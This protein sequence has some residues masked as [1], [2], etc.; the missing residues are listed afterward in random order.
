MCDEADLLGCQLSGIPG[1]LTL[2]AVWVL[3]AGPVRLRVREVCNPRFNN[4]RDCRAQRRSN[5]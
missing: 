2:A 3:D 4:R 5:Q 1:V